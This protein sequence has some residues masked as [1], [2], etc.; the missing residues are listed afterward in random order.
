ML[1]IL[2]SLLC[3]FLYCVHCIVCFLLVISKRWIL[4]E[5][6]KCAKK[7]LLQPWNALTLQL[8]ADLDADLAM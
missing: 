8:D 5:Y 2:L 1:W 3:V 4:R 7:V 6:I